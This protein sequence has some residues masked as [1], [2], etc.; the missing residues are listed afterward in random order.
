MK[1]HKITGGGSVQLHV[2]E[3]GNQ[4]GRPVMFLHGV[5]QSSLTCGDL[6]LLWGAGSFRFGL[7]QSEHAAGR[8]SDEAEPTHAVYF[9]HV[10][11][12]LSA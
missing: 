11:H 8:I 2:V 4:R 1:T 10:L 7:P 9:G 3:T 5:S 12:D 6:D